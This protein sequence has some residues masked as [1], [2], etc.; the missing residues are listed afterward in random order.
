MVQLRSR[1]TAEGMQAMHKALQLD[2]GAEMLNDVAYEMAEADTNLVEA[3][4]YSRRSVKE[5]EE[6][7]ER[8]DFQNIQQ[9]DLQLPLTIIIVLTGT[10]WVGSTSRWAIWRGRKVT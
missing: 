7:S 6:R 1:K 10:H 4:D 2:S 3:L 5:V 9:A 8:V